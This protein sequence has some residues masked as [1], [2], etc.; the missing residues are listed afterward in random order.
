MKKVQL[1]IATLSL[2]ALYSQLCVCSSSSSQSNSTSSSSSSASSS[3]SS[4]SVAHKKNAVEV[5]SAAAAAAKNTAAIGS[6]STPAARIR[7]DTAFG[8]SL[9]QHYQQQEDSPSILLMNEMLDAGKA[10]TKGIRAFDADAGIP[11]KSDIQLHGLYQAARNTHNN[12]SLIKLLEDIEG[13]PDIE[14]LYKILETQTLTPEEKITIDQSAK[15]SEKNQ[16]EQLKKK[17]HIEHLDTKLL[18]AFKNFKKKSSKRAQEAFG[19][20]IKDIKTIK[21]LFDQ[22]EIS[23]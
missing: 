3:S 21:G 5:T 14:A 7:V 9:A 17:H 2:I 6:T 10:V 12:L 4:S 19:L 8:R 11:F 15:M 1:L 22:L 13:I 20:A 23:K 16:F 18:S